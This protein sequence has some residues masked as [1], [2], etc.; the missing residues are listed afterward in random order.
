MILPHARAIAQTTAAICTLLISD[1]TTTDQSPLAVQQHQQSPST[2]TS[3][4]RLLHSCNAQSNCVSS[5]YRE[6]PNRYVSPFKI[7]NKPNVAFQRAVRDMKN[8]DYDVS[9][10]EIVPTDYYIHATVSGTA[11]S[12]LDDIELLFAE[13]IVNV[14]CEARVTL[15]PPPFCVKKNCINGNMDQRSRVEK[16]GYLLGLPAN[17][18]EEMKG[19]AK[20]TPIFM[21]SDRV[22]GFEDGDC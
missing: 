18:Q 8:S 21:N 22:P 3:I 4:T 11:P 19:E 5:N 15:P 16:I 6:P 10:V 17:D 14:K 1:P 20:W 2:T 13:D 7:A 12:S 9:I